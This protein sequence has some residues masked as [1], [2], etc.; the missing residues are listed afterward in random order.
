MKA[1]KLALFFCVLALLVYFASDHPDVLERAVESIGT[2]SEGTS[3]FGAY[4][5]PGI[6]NDFLNSFITAIC[7]LALVAGLA[8]S[9]FKLLVNRK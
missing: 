1:L 9:V 5:I 8:Y 4:R 2:G 6:E 3:L 7:G